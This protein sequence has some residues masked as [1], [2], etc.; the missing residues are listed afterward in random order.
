MLQNH[1]QVLALSH[2]LDESDFTVQQAALHTPQAGFTIQLAVVQQLQS[3]HVLWHQMEHQ[4]EV[5]LL[6]SEKGFILLLGSF[7]SRE[8]AQATADQFDFENEVWIRA[9]KNVLTDNMQSL[10]LNDAI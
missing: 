7:K 9:W 1:M 3:L 5:Y 8:E 10:I 4:S 2:E 6:K